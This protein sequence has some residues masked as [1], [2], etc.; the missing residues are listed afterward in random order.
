MVLRLNVIAVCMRRELVMVRATPGNP[1]FEIDVE[2]PVE[3]GDGHPDGFEEGSDRV[4]TR[5]LALF[6]FVNNPAAG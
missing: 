4:G 1:W 6:P 2:A 5:I 3:R